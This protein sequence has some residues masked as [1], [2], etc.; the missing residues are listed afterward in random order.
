MRRIETLGSRDPNRWLHTQREL[1]IS[2]RAR[3]AGFSTKA[4]LSLAVFHFIA[5]L[6]DLSSREYLQREQAKRTLEWLKTVQ[7]AQASEA[8]RRLNRA[9]TAAAASASF[10]SCSPST[11]LASRYQSNFVNLITCNRKNQS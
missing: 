9:P 3:M 10:D 5:G 1:P 6:A 4:Q 2:A 11:P 7:I 8:S